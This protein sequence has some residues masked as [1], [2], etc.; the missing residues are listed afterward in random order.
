MPEVFSNPPS[1]LWGQS[2]T[3]FY[4]WSAFAVTPFN[5]VFKHYLSFISYLISFT[6]TSEDMAEKADE[7]ER[8]EMEIK[9]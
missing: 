2:F 6:L 4:T 3:L 8:E 7:Q 1:I 9:I 5:L